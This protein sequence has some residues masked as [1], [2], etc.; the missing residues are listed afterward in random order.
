V[1]REHVR[2]AVDSRA[3]KRV[4]EEAGLLAQATAAT[5]R[6]RVAVGRGGR[7][8]A[9]TSRMAASR[10]CWRAVA[11]ARAELLMTREAVAIEQASFATSGQESAGARN[12]WGRY[13]RGHRILQ[14]IVDHA[15]ERFHRPL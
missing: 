7:G 8:A 2:G 4:G 6:M 5:E 12:R 9:R 1:G 14:R 11:A 13:G 3:K 15:W 10:T